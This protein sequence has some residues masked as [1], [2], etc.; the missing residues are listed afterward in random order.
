MWLI[1]SLMVGLCGPGVPAKKIDYW[2]VLVNSKH[3]IPTHFI[4]PTSF[5]DEL[6]SFSLVHPIVR[7]L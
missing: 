3:G 5:D 2:N 6:A 4:Q 1:T 7:M